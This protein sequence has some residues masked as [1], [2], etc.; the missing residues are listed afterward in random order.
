MRNNFFNYFKRFYIA[1]LLLV[2]YIPLI[3][4]VIW[5]FAGAS[6]KGNI[7]TEFEGGLDG[8]IQLFSDNSFLNGL[9]NTFIIMG[10]VTPISVFIATITCFSAW[11]NKRS[12]VKI[13]NG[14]S[15]ISLVNPEI[16]TGI[17]LTLLFASTWI[18]L[19]LDLG[20]FTII[21][22]HISFCTP[23]ALITIFPRMQKFNKNLLDASRDLGYSN[24]KTFF[25]IIIPYLLPSLIAAMSLVAVMS[26]DDF[27]I[28]N[29][30]RGRVTTISTEI[31]L[32]AKGIK[33]WAVAFGAILI[34][35]F[36]IVIS[37]KGIIGFKKERKN[38]I[39]EMARIIKNKRIYNGK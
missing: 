20:F 10:I 19:G 22:S 13:T 29:L 17:S 9:F 36:I 37:V 39:D 7:T 31:Y 8:Y 2:I 26:F 38:K 6:D 24:F 4:L 15:R 21:L 35:I 1:I 28:T 18:P 32:M 5:S 11:N 33:A 27:I 12:V 14:I 30:V 16:I 34:T 3:T 25:K 23:Y